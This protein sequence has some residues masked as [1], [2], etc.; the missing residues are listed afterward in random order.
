M[1]FRNQSFMPV[2]YQSADLF[3]L[4]SKF[5]E[6]WGLA[7]NEAMACGKAILASNKVGCAIDLVKPGVNGAIFISDDQQS[8]LKELDRLTESKEQLNKY[9]AASK[10]IIKDWNFTNIAVAIEHQLLNEARRLF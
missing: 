8:L 3:C 6:T 5:G 2:I 4:P 10:E 9:G 1:D 7:I